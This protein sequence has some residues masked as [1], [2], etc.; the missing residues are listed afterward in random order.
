MLLL[1]DRT[2]DGSFSSFPRLLTSQRHQMP[3]HS[4]HDLY[5][6]PPLPRVTPAPLIFFFWRCFS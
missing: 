4:P 3:A 5:V 1:I 2:K 6:Q